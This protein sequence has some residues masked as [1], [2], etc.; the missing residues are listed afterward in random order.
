M[1]HRLEVEPSTL[2]R[3]TLAKSL[4]PDIIRNFRKVTSFAATISIS[5]CTFPSCSI[6]PIANQLSIH[7]KR[8]SKTHSCQKA[9]PIWWELYH[10]KPQQPSASLSRE[11][12]L[13]EILKGLDIIVP[14]QVQV[15]MREIVEQLPNWSMTSCGKL[16]VI[17]HFVSCP[18]SRNKV[19]TSISRHPSMPHPSRILLGGYVGSKD[20]AEWMIAPSSSDANSIRLLQ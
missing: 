1:S 15:L 12:S 17:T 3:F 11:H 8:H 9:D 16:P 20:V 4:Q 2:K 18:L 7:R 13:I 6:N 10:C 19:S 14:L 5:T